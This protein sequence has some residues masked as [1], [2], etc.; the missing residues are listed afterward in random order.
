ME[1]QLRDMVVCYVCPGAQA[2][3]NVTRGAAAGLLETHFANLTRYYELFSSM[4]LPIYPPTRSMES[5]LILGYWNGN[6]H[7]FLKLQERPENLSRYT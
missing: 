7:M 6:R 2:H 1:Q 4:V 3:T 5:N